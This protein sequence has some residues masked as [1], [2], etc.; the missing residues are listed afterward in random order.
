MKVYVVVHFCTVLG[1]FSTR[2]NAEKYILTFSH[3]REDFD[4]IMK[5]LETEEVE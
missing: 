4:I 3:F 5:E 2:E 1:V